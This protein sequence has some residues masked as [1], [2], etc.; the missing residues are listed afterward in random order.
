MENLVPSNQHKVYILYNPERVDYTVTGEELE[1]LGEGGRNLWKDFCLVALS[2]GLP[3]LINAVA[4]TDA[5]NFTLSLTLFLN[6]LIGVV[7]IALS[8]VFGIFWYSTNKKSIDLVALIKNKPKYEIRPTVE[9]V[10]AMQVI[11]VPSPNIE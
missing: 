10:G 9:N 1:K 8:V 6:Y 4:D 2:L 7:G 3:C 5:Q 11:S